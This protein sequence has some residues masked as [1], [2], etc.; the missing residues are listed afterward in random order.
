LKKQLVPLRV[1]S[2][3]MIDYNA[4]LDLDPNEFI[5]NEYEFRWEYSEDILQF[6]NKIRSRV[7]DLGWY[8][9]HNPDGMF[10]IKL[11]ELVEDNESQSDKWFQPIFILRTRNRNEIIEKLE[12]I[13]QEVAEGRL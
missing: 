1:P 6:S 13:M 9:D 5:D 11:V 12:W 7:L 10:N 2:G 3:W 8:P 4:F